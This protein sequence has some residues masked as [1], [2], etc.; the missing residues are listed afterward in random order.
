MILINF[1][2]LLSFII[3]QLLKKDENA[4]I[5]HTYWSNGNESSLSLDE[6]Y[7]QILGLTEHNIL[8]AEIITNAYYSIL[9]KTAS[10]RRSGEKVYINLRD[11]RAARNYLIDS[12][13]YLGADN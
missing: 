3:Y 8:S 7:I 1:L 12:C 6:Y 4:P 13:H 9:A 5:Q 10:R 2:V 11:L